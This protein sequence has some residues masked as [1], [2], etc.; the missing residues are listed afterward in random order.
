MFSVRKS[1]KNEHLRSFILCVLSLYPVQVIRDRYSVNM[2]PTWY[3]YVFVAFFHVLIKKKEKKK[4]KSFITYI[5]YLYYIFDIWPK[6]I[7][8][9][10]ILPRKAKRGWTLMWVTYKVWHDIA[11]TNI[12][13]SLAGNMTNRVKAQVLKDA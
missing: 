4:K 8:P 6:T 5:H 13:F 11:H 7:P 12:L 9:Q 1:L 10:S 2:C 3:L